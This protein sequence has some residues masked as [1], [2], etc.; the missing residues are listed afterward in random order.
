M[1]NVA[2]ENLHSYI[3]PPP[4]PSLT[5]N[6]RSNSLTNSKQHSSASRFSLFL[7]PFCPLPHCSPNFFLLLLLLLPRFG[8]VP[9]SKLL[10]AQDDRGREEGRGGRSPGEIKS[11][12]D[13]CES[14][15][16]GARRSGRMRG[17]DEENLLELSREFRGGRVSGGN[18]WVGET[19]AA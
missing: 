3:P 19:V 12:A 6:P 5:N 16:F 17:E 18:F 4:S 14:R 1:A 10:L 2:R 15:D 13:E 11:A 9:R 7:A 8:F